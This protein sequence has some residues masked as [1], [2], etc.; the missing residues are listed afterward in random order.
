MITPVWRQ[1]VA[2]VLI[3]VSTDYYCHSHFV[4]GQL[5]WELQSGCGGTDS[6]R[7][8]ERK[9]ITK[10]AGWRQWTNLLQRS[11]SPS[12]Q[13]PVLPDFNLFSQVIGDAFALAVVGYGIAISLGR[14]FALKYGYKVDSNQVGWQCWKKKP[15]ENVSI[16]ILKI[17]VSFFKMCIL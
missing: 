9:I 6:L 16:V 11:V 4:A 2:P 1:P 12:L 3:A 8:R 14:I 15:S 7:V 5:E 17:D 10:L 13:A